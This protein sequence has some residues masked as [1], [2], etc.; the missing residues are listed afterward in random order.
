MSVTKICIPVPNKELASPVE[1]CL[2]PIPVTVFINKKEKTPSFSKM[3]NEMIYVASKENIDYMIICSHRVRPKPEDMERMVSLLNDGYGFVT[4]LRLACFGFKLD[5]IREIGFFDE[6]FIPAGYED[7]DFFLRLQEA[8]IGMYEDKSV[9]Y[10]PGPSL[11]QQE[12]FDFDDTEFKQ[13]ITYKYFFKK[14]E[15]D[16]KK[17][18]YKRKMSEKEYI[19]NIGPKRPN[20]YFKTWRDS[21]LLFDNVQK[22][23]SIMNFDKIIE[24]TILI[25]GGSGSLGQQFIRKY[26][27]MEDSKNKIYVFSRDENKHWML[28]Q[29]PD[30]KDVNF[31]IGDIRDYDRVKEVMLNVNPN[32]VIIASAMKHIDRCEFNVNEALMTNTIGTMNVCKSI[33]TNEH[34]LK[35]LKNVVFVST[36]KATK[37]INTYGMTKALSEKIIIEYSEKM[38][39]SYIKFNVVRY[40]NVLNSRG[41]IIPKL[42]EHQGNT[43]YLTHKDMTRFIMT[44]DEAVSLIENAILYAQPG[45]TV[46]PKLTSM[47]IYDLFEI[48]SEKYNKKIEITS[49]RPGEKLHEELLN[50]DELRKAYIKGD[51]YIL[52]VFYDEGMKKLTFDDKILE[53]GYSSC[54]NKL[55][56]NDLRDY[57]ISLNLL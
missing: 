9:Q 47:N 25:F 49:I 56:K 27:N 11:W 51:Y 36:D 30:F 48:F 29:D 37:P 21:Q 18:I 19:Y 24:K 50:E 44:Q 20:V 57:L 8:D 15:R 39:K 5:L 7:D 13:P 54:N 35:R 55:S 16:T 40:G 41:S 3:I 38:K 6:N 4:F 32:I 22:H 46:I 28:S 34:A 14:W 23:F 26:A 45:D 33:H 12:L 42:K 53:S 43:L 10:L 1:E 2:K 31:I 17:M 52:P